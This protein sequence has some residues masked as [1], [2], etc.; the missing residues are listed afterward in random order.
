[1]RCSLRRRKL[2]LLLLEAPDQPLVSTLWI[3]VDCS[4]KCDAGLRRRGAWG[5]NTKST[6]HLGLFFS[7]FLSLVWFKIKFCLKSFKWSRSKAEEAPSSGGIL[8]FPRSKPIVSWLTDP[9]SFS[10]L[11][12]EHTPLPDYKGSGGQRRAD[13]IFSLHRQRTQE[14]QF[15]P[16]ASGEIYFHH[17]TSTLNHWTNQK[18]V[19]LDAGAPLDI[20]VHSWTQPLVWIWNL[21]ILGSGIYSVGDWDHF[22]FIVSDSLVKKQPGTQDQHLA[23]GYNNVFIPKTISKRTSYSRSIRIDVPQSRWIVIALVVLKLVN[24]S[25]NISSWTQHLCVFCS[26]SCHRVMCGNVKSVT[27]SKGRSWMR[28]PL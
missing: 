1:M 25:T 17:L 19:V 16:V 5:G 22:A 6:I 10:S 20:N 11:H 2:G 12:S 8:I 24:Q 13:G 9:C 26:R 18:E 27:D 14:G 4:L 21:L 7:F 23:Q 3:K 15:P 28:T